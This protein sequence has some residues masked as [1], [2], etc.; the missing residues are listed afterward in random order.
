MYTTPTFWTLFLACI[1]LKQEKWTE[2]D[3]ID[4]KLLI[5]DLAPDAGVYASPVIVIVLM[6]FLAQ[7]ALTSIEVMAWISNY[8]QNKRVEYYYSSIS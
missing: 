7:I 1:G 6:Y 3:Y 2:V 8:I 4:N 5:I